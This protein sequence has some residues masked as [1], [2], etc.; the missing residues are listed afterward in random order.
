M[1]QYGLLGTFDYL[2]LPQSELEF[3]FAGVSIMPSEGGF[4]EH[5]QE[6]IERAGA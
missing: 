3:S 2:V 5:V 4:H 6:R 1:K